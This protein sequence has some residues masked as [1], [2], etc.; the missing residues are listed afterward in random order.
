VAVNFLIRDASNPD[1]TVY[2]TGV[3]LQDGTPKPAF[4]AFRFPFV[5][6]R[7][8]KDKVRAWGRSPATGELEIQREGP[9]GW[10]TVKRLSVNDGGVFTTSLRI[11]GGA[12]LRAVVGSDQSIPWSLSG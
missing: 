3:F 7:L 10:H 9:D 8:S 4:D 12:T 2:G 5:G 11:R 6:D 1:G